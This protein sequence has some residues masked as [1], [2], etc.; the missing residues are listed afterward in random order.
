MKVLGLIPAR[1]GS[2]GVPRKNI[3][4]LHGK[5]LLGYTAEAALQS[6]RLTRVVLST[7]DDEIANVGRQYGLD[8][9]FLRPQNL[10][11]D[12]SP[13][14]DVVIHAL[15]SLDEAGDTFDSVCL[16][17]PTNP[18]RR[19][20][21]IDNCIELFERSGA[22]SVISVLPVPAE[23]NPGWVYWQDEEGRLLISTG[24]DEPVTRRQDLPNAYHRDG[25]VYVTRTET[26]LARN[27]LYGD[28]VLGYEMSPE[29]SVNIDTE[30]DWLKAEERSGERE[31][32]FLS[33]DCESK[34]NEDLRF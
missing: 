8:V 33:F 22:D 34:A 10:A 25:S 14:L 19:T 26:I 16:L 21:D 5:P 27:S 2:K 32:M 1:G 4:H 15:K 23:Y 6:R 31:K 17:Q 30:E 9:P 20:V 11:M 7:E 12:S 24:D 3:R 18:F 29:F 28:C 13:T